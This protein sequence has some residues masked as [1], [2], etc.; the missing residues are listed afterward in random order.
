[1]L[2]PTVSPIERESSRVHGAGRFQRR[3]RKQKNRQGAC[4]LGL[5]SA[6][7]FPGCD[8][9]PAPS[10]PVPE[11][12]IPSPPEVSEPLPEPHPECP[13]AEAPPGSYQLQSSMVRS[14]RGLIR[15]RAGLNQ[16]FGD[17]VAYGDFN[18]DGLEDFFVAVMDGSPHPRPVEM[19]LNTGDGFRRD[20][21]IWRG[22]IPGLVHPRKAL[23]GDFN[24]DGRL[25]IF[26]AGHG[27][28]HPPWPGEP[29]VLILSTQDGGLRDTGDLRGFTGFL[30]GA[31]S[32]DIDRDGDLDVFVTDIRQPF[33]L[34]NEGDGR[35]TYDLSAVPLDLTE[36]NVYTV[37]LLD[38][39][40][41]GFP[42][43]LIGGHEHERTPTAIYWG[44]CAGL[45]QVLDKT[46][47]PPVP[48]FGI[49]VDL[50]AEDLDGDGMREIFITRTRDDIYDG[51]FL[52]ILVADDG[53]EFKDETEHRIVGG[54]DPET[55][56]VRWLRI[57]DLNDD[58]HR[59][60]WDDS[61]WPPRRTWLNDGTGRFTPGPELPTV[62]GMP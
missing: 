53:V 29:P 21:D 28:D 31:A 13:A 57:Q 51:F 8:E 37:E 5:L 48:G 15:H 50:D 39:N 56:W 42:D 61:E 59:D 6:I 30:H 16:D 18:G 7:G 45:F 46:V 2:F 38:V 24:A 60:L 9:A 47:L 3:T 26:V 22:D 44:N 20:R 35:L 23:A 62:D 4:V 41:D 49:V 10:S 58:G 52:Q 34:K 36:K 19:W 14:H 12:V 11:T 17:A 54:S 27:Y 40:E 43:L 1:M 55:N 33:I 25:D 32:A